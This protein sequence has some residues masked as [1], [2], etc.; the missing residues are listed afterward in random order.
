MPYVVT[1]DDRCPASK[2]WGVTNQQTGDLHGCH[3]TKEHARSQ[4]RA[5]YAAADDARP[6][7]SA[8]KAPPQDAT[9]VPADWAD[10]N[11]NGR[12]HLMQPRTEGS[13]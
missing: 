10:G 11:E 3:P 13:T 7:R 5:L 8:A 12:A 9:Q 4:Q 2:P 1:R 6:R